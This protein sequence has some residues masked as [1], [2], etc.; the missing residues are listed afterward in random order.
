MPSF[1]AALTAVVLAASTGQATASA[2]PPK[3]SDLGGTPGPVQTCEIHATDQSYT[4]DISVPADYP[5]PKN[6]FDYVRETRDGFLNVTK[7]PDGRTTPYAL[8]TTSTE[9]YSAVPPRGTQSVVLETYESM[10]G[11]HPQTFFKAFNWDQGYRKPIT[12]DTLFRDGTAPLPVLYPLVAAE[13]EKQLG[14][15]NLLSPTAGLDPATYQNFVITNDSLIFFFSQGEVL[16]EPAGA[17]AVT[18]PRGPVDAMIA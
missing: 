13:L 10:G 5:D 8:D 15:P 4:V 6:L 17:V 11:P 7:T 9:Y 18:V 2:A 1:A 3:C 14:Q 16:P 12:I